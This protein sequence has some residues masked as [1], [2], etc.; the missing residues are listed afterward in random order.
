M[1]SARRRARMQG[2]E[3]QPEGAPDWLWGF[4]LNR[5]VSARRIAG[6]PIDLGDFGSERAEWKQRRDAWLRAHGVSMEEYERMQRAYWAQRRTL[7]VVK[8]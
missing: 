7:R 8:P 3:E 1:V 5:W 2:A 4:P 6:K